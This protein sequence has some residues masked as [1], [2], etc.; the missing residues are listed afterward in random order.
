[1]TRPQ[2]P[3]SSAT[4]RAHSRAGNAWGKPAMPIARRVALAAPAILL[5]LPRARAQGN[6]P[7]RPVRVIV[8]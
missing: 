5:G 7:N 1:M 3:W 8:P 4:E 2:D 6:F